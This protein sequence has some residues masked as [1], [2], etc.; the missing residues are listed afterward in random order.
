MLGPLSNSS[1]LAEIEATAIGLRSGALAP[2]DASKRLRATA[3]ALER[4]PYPLARAAED[5]AHAL[6]ICSWHLEEGMEADL[7]MLAGKLEAWVSG[8]SRAVA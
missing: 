8:A 4:L 6:E 1:L 3:S 2:I 5:I 7:A